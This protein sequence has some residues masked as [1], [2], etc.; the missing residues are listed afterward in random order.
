MRKH[1]GEI[2]EV[3]NEADVAVHIQT[4]DRFNPIKGKKNF[5]FSMF[6]AEAIP[7]TYVDGLHK[8]DHIIVPCNH[9][10]KLFHQYVDK[11]IDVCHEGVLIDKYT[12]VQRKH[13]AREKTNGFNEKKKF[14][15]LWVGAPNPRKGFEET[16]TAWKYSGAEENPDIELYCKTT[17]GA[18]E[19]L[20]QE[21]VRH[22]V[23]TINSQING[24]QITTRATIRNQGPAPALHL[25]IPEDI[26]GGPG[27]VSKNLCSQHS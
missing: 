16:I 8:A 7:K 25:D 19:Q 3:T 5:L 27:N 12:F 1:T 10:K 17:Q 24:K 21:K 6:E 11:P 2:A 14:R 13:P 15:F 4:A 26:N 18:K 22:A 20:Q 23:I 9:N